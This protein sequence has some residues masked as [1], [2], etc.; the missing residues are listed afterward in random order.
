M[1]YSCI[2]IDLDISLLSDSDTIVCFKG[3]L[4]NSVECGF[5]EAFYV[6]V[7]LMSH[8]FQMSFAH[9]Q[10]MDSSCPKFGRKPSDTYTVSWC[11]F[12]LWLFCFSF[13]FVRYTLKESC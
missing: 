1:V 13:Q 9:T 5:G 7:V 4:R 12:V 2:W 11:V 3:R 10:K 6:C 8:R